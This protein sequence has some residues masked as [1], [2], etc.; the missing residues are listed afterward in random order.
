MVNPITIHCITAKRVL[1]YLKGTIDL[2]LIYEKGLE[3]LNV[4]GYSN[5]EFADDVI[6]KRTLRERYSF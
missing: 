3:N 2:C 4:I 1:R 6:K 5:S